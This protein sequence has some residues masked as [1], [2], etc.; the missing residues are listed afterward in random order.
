MTGV[1]S[2]ERSDEHI[3]DC[4][5]FRGLEFS[6]SPNKIAD[7]SGLSSEH[8]TNCDLFLKR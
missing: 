1:F 2:N 3:T 6:E 4:D 7:Y 5:M 8:I